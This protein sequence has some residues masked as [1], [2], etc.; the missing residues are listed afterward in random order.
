[1]VVRP[2]PVSRG[3]LVGGD[4]KFPVVGC[5]WGRRGGVERTRRCGWAMDIRARMKWCLALCG[6][7]VAVVG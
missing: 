5:V 2:P 7:S 1:M 4:R 3:C 6:G